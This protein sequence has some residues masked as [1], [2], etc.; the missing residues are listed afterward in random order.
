MR[1]GFPNSYR[2]ILLSFGL[3]KWS[4]RG[5]FQGMKRPGVLVV[6]NLGFLLM[7]TPGSGQSASSESTAKSVP[8]ELPYKPGQATSR[9]ATLVIP[10]IEFNDTPILKALSLLAEECQRLTGEK[11]SPEIVLTPGAAA[12]D[13]KITLQMQNA[14]A[15]EVLKYMITLANLKL[16]WRADGLVVI[17]ELEKRTQR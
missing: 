14:P 1:D 16:S 8:K 7:V 17:Q 2:G 3:P 4:P 10:K 12:Q 15:M 13:A 9:L 5:T 6:A 11:I